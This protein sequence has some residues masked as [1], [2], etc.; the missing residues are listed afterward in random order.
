MA[1]VTNIKNFVESSLQF[2]VSLSLAPPLP[3]QVKPPSLLLYN[4]SC[5]N[6]SSPFFP[7][8]RQGKKF[9]S[10]RDMRRSSDTE[11]KGLRSA[12]KIRKECKIFFQKYLDETECTNVF[13][14]IQPQKNQDP[15]RQLLLHLGLRFPDADDDRSTSLS[16]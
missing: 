13:C 7:S 9:F 8:Y 10:L 16:N 6:K 4:L 11:I 1:K 2:P 3:V 14:L 15:W 12:E 5:K